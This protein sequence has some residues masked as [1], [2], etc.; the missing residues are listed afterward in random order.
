M[1]V[2]SMAMTV[3][4]QEVT[5]E[6][7]VE[8]EAGTPKVGVGVGAE[9]G[10][11]VVATVKEDGEEDIDQNLAKIVAEA[12]PGNAVRVE[13]QAE[14]DT[15]AES[16]REVETVEGATKAEAKEEIE[17]LVQ[18][19]AVAAVAVL[20]MEYTVKG[21]AA[22]AA[23]V[24]VTEDEEVSPDAQFRCAQCLREWLVFR[25]HSVPGELKNGKNIYPCLVAQK[26]NRLY[27][28]LQI[29]HKLTLIFP[30]V[31][32]AGAD[33]Q[34]PVATEDRFEILSSIEY[35]RTL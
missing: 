3:F 9:A 8:A 20:V 7:G 29:Q 26:S 17:A 12:G 35:F 34:K 25:I 14:A 27:D 21:V 6:A 1:L 23:V 4:V 19:A 13:A 24:A 18:A 16:E 32:Y 10:V 31:G 22:G 28:F 5:A 11:A 15:R 2:T 33:D 30:T